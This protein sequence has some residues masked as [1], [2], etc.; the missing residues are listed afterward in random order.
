[1]S[2]R[3]P[4]CKP[5]EESKS[6]LYNVPYRSSYDGTMLYADFFIPPKPAPLLLYF[7]GWHLTKES[8]HRT[9][10]VFARDFLVVNVDM[11]GRG[12]C[13]GKP[14]C[15]CWELLD[16]IDALN[17]ARQHFAQHIAA[18]DLAYCFG[19]SGGGGNTLAAM[20]KFPDHFAAGVAMCPISDYAMWYEGDTKGEFR[21]E[22]DVWI[23]RPPAEAPEAYRSRSG[24]YLLE[25]LQ[26]PLRL[27]HGSADERVP[28]AHSRQYKER[29]DSL[30]KKVE[31]VELDGA[32]HSLS[33]E[34]FSGEILDFFHKHASVTRL[35]REGFWRIGGYLQTR[36]QRVELTSSEA[37]VEARYL[38]D[39]DGYLKQLEILGDAGVDAG[40]GYRIVDLPQIQIDNPISIS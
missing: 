37:W 8:A 30:G 26:A 3:M 16:G 22:M 33:E 1:M 24:L 19:G 32:G 5:A 13:G 35:P 28:V 9:L 27:Y 18:G 11:R 21:D 7:H 6:I 39:E 10:D 2:E 38:L 20:A 31:Y 17:Y 14:D 34:A 12:E 25:N 4:E 29:A 15:N 40:V 36:R 23:G